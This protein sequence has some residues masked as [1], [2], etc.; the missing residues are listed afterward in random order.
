[1]SGN[2]AGSGRHPSEETL[3]GYAAGGLDEAYRVVVATHLAG[4]SACR[5]AV[6]LAERVGGGVLDGLD[7]APMAAGAL[8][9]ALARLDEPAPPTPRLTP[10]PPGLPATL[11]G[12]QLGRWR[13]IGK[14]FGFATL[15]PPE[16]KRAG[17]HLFRIE[18]GMRIAGHGHHGLELTMVLQG[19][20]RDHSGVFAAGDVAENAEDHEHAPMAVGDVSCIS[21]IA[22][23]GRLQ[24]HHWM[25]RLLQ[26]LI[27]F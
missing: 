26:P 4:C 10:P 7:A 19:A 5:D 16:G 24:F 27:G 8:D 20:F 17:L 21:L 15:M 14:G 18:P 22:L 3:L 25:A 1:M 12:Y 11:A 2:M 6:L 9:R 23:S 13:N